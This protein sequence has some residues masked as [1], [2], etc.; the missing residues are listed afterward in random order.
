MQLFLQFFDNFETV[1]EVLASSSLTAYAS[2]ASIGQGVAVGNVLISASE[3]LI[4]HFG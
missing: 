4:S 1:D 2:V 3:G